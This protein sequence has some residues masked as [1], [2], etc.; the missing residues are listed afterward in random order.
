LLCVKTAGLAVHCCCGPPTHLIP[1]PH[2]LHPLQLATQN[3]LRCVQYVERKNPVYNYPHNRD[4]DPT[5]QQQ[6]VYKQ[7]SVGGGGN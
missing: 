1:I 2:Q 5:R 4:R 6:S 3:I 7:G